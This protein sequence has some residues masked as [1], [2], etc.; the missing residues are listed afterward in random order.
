MIK[1]KLTDKML[2]KWLA[3]KQ[4]LADKRSVAL[5]SLQ[6]A[7]YFHARGETAQCFDALFWFHFYRDEVLELMTRHRQALFDVEAA[8]VGEGLV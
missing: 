3:S 1:R 7:I 8:L 6:S 5:A 2:C 4:L